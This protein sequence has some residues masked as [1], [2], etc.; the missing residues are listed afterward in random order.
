MRGLAQLLW[1][2]PRER[3]AFFPIAIPDYVR[4]GPINMLILFQE[5]T[6]FP[7][8]ERLLDVHAP[9]LAVLGDQD[10]LMPPA[11]Q[12][13]DV[14]VQAGQHVE[15]AVINGAGHA[16]NFSHPADLVNTTVPWLEIMGH[17]RG[18]RTGHE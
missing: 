9:T 7:F 3:L 8:L 12:V 18:S 4:F 13:R 14:A 16:I 5:M 2:G 10:P 11:T 1:D 6:R 15:V 17:D